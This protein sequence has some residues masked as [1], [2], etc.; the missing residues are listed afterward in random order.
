MECGD[1]SPLLP[2]PTRRQSLAAFSGAKKQRASFDGDKSPAESGEDSPHCVAAQAALCESCP[3]VVPAELFRFASTDLVRFAAEKS[4]SRS[5][6]PAT[7]SA[8]IQ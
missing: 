7:R 4:F 1:L 3:S 2:W 8:A 6:K 5:R